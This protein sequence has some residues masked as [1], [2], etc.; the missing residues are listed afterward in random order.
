MYYV[1][2]ISAMKEN[3]EDKGFWI[4]WYDQIYER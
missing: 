1:I 4:G 2:L 3:K